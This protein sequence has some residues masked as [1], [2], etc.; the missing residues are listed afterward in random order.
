MDAFARSCS[1]ETMG[2][3]ILEPFLLERADGRLVMFDKGP[4]AKALQ[5]TVGDGVY[6]DKGRQ[7]FVEIK[8]EQRFTGNLFLETWSNRNL[9]DRDSHASLGSNPGWL[10][11]LKAD[12]L[13]Y[14]FLDNDHLYVFDLFKLKR[15]AFSLP[16]KN[17]HDGRLWDYRE[18]EQGA[19][20]QRNDTR[21]RIVPI[22]DL[23]DE[24][25]FRLLHPRELAFSKIEGRA[26]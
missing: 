11:K 7:W 15:W 8:T 12:L 3:S 6:S 22:A 1:V 9:K 4:M 24:P 10:L 14:Y 23:V 16:G 25:G 21:G 26:A 17:G 18:V 2:R 19:N 13:L 20:V 5:E